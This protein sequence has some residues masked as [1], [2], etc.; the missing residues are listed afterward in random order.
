MCLSRLPLLRG[1]W[2]SNKSSTP[3]TSPPETIEV[4]KLDPRGMIRN[5]I[6]YIKNSLP[7]LG[8]VKGDSLTDV[9]YKQGQWD[10]LRFIETKVVGRR[11]SSAQPIRRR[12]GE[13]V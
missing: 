3:P 6:E 11:I 7:K 12:E 9:A 2:T 5:D 1:I 13:G 8:Y 4:V 10:L